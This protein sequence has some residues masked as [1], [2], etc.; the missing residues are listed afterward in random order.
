MLQYCAHCNAVPFTATGS[1]AETAARPWHYPEHEHLAE[2][3]DLEDRPAPWRYSACGTIIE[4]PDETEQAREAAAAESRERAREARPPTVRSRSRSAGSTSKRSLTR[5]GG[6]CRQ[7]CGHD[8]A[9]PADRARAWPRHRRSDR[10]VACRESLGSAATRLR[11]RPA[12]EPGRGGRLRSL[13]ARRPQGQGALVAGRPA[14]RGQTR[15]DRGN[16]VWLY[17]KAPT[18]REASAIDT[19]TE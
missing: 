3:G 6:W 11:R 10:G 4:A 15:T 9:S 1:L 2:P 7:G 14:R 18:E 16:V 17:E 12:R 5:P 19:C 13:T 8:P